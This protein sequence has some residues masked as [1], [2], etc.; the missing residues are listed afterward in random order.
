VFTIP[1]VTYGVFRYLFLVQQRDEGGNPSRA[2]YR[3]LPLFVTIL[4]WIALVLGIIYRN[5]F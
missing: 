2:L 3:D 4:G 1:F 5:G